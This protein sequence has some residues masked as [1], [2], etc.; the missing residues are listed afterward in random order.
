[1]LA[2]TTYLGH[3]HI[4][5]TYLSEASDK[6]VYQQDYIMRRKPIKHWSYLT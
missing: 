6:Y 1:M 3:A 4:K 5:S 2:L